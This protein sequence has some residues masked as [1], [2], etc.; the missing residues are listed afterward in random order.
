MVQNVIDRLKKVNQS[1]VTPLLK[2]FCAQ[3]FS[4][5]SAGAFHA[6][7]RTVLL[8]FQDKRVK[9]SIFLQDGLQRADGELVLSG[10]GVLPPGFDTPGRLRIIAPGGA[11]ISQST[12]EIPAAPMCHEHVAGD[13]C[14]SLGLNMYVMASAE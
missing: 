7:R 9:V 10:S 6:I 4:G 1:F 8:F 12:L 11:V 5:L 3:T 13:R 2:N 14:S